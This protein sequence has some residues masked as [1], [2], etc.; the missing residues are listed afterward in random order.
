MIFTRTKHGANRLTKQLTKDG[1][2]A[3]AIHSNKSQATRTRVLA[4][5][6]KGEVKILV[7]TDVAARGLDIE[8]LPHVVNF[9]LPNIP[10]DYV[11]RIGRTGR[12][13]QNG[14]ALSLV[15]IDEQEFLLKIQKLLKQKIT[16]KKIDGFQMETAAKSPVKK[17]P[18]KT[19]GKTFGN[20]KKSGVR[21]STSGKDQRRPVQST[22][23]NNRKSN[24]RRRGS[25]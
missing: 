13:G 5:F 3:A 25:A 19:T 10:E 22:R 18:G 6:K 14:V 8:N 21:K 15:C 7:A 2:H 17:T 4:N 23:K 11:H 20:K 24:S 12:A 16:V 9:D 1:I